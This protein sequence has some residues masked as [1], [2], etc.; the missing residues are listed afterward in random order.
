MVLRL[1]TANPQ[2]R[3][4]DDLICHHWY[5]E[6]IPHF[7]RSR[8]CCGCAAW[9]LTSLLGCRIHSSIIKGLCDNDLN[10]TEHTVY[11]WIYNLQKAIFQSQAL[12]NFS[13]RSN[14]KHPDWKHQKL[15]RLMSGPGQEGSTAGYQNQQ[16]IT[17]T[18]IQS[19]G[20]ISEV[21][22]LHRAQ[23][24]LKGNSH[25]SHDHSA[26]CR[27]AKDTE[28]S[29]AVL[30]DYRAAS[31]LTLWNSWTHPPHPVLFNRLFSFSYGCKI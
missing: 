7:L 28:V 2:V 23:R 5:R 6:S 12:V 16:T 27:L 11:V 30:L 25:P 18:H 17:C 15:A 26:C 24:I 3:T 4:K 31:L 1:T 13:E 21:R 14:R 29:T 19:I 20:D 9:L 8:L 22:F 10:H